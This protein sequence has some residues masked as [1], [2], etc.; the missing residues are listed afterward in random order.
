[1]LRDQDGAELR[2][3]D[4]ERLVAE[5]LPMIKLRNSIE[6]FRVLATGQFERHSGTSWRP[7]S[8]STVNHR[9][10]TAAM[11]DSRDFLAAKRR[12]ETE[13][14]LPIGPKIAFTC[15]LDVNDH[16]AIWDT[17]DQVHG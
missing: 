5:G 1:S 6:L 4:M 7:R 10:L 15:G 14:L 17:L 3:V 9:T 12:S 13:V 16:A 8:G 11:I 2:Y